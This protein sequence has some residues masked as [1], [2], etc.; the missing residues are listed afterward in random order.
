MKNSSLT[1]LLF[2]INFLI[3]KDPI[4]KTAH[5]TKFKFLS[6]KLTSP[7]S[8]FIFNNKVVIFIWEEPLHGILIENKETYNSYK[9]YFEELWK[10]AK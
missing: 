4:L 10:I 9:E 6:Q 8:T 5:N 2:K 7:T 1:C 3:K